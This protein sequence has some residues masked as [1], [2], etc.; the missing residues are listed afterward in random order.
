MPLY[1]DKTTTQM[2]TVIS[3]L[4]CFLTKNGPSPTSFCLFPFFFKQF[5][6]LNFSGIRIRIDRVVGEYADHLTTTTAL[7][8]PMLVQVP[9]TN[10]IEKANHWKLDMTFL[11]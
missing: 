4:Q 5:T 9:N 6:E 3:N 1:N 11:E 7:E 2:V 10:V 8:S